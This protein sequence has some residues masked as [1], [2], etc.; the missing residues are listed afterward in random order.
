M[1]KPKL[2]VYKPYN[3]KGRRCAKQKERRKLNYELTSTEDEQDQ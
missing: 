3:S 2:T 1:P